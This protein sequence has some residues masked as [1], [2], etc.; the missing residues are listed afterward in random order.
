MK[1]AILPALLI[2]LLTA[3]SVYANENYDLQCTLTDGNQMTLSHS[4]DTVYIAFLGPN[5]D[6]E[7]SDSVMKLD[8]NIDAVRQIKTVSPSPMLTVEATPV[9]FDEKGTSVHVIFQELERKKYVSY[10]VTNSMGREIS[11]MDCKSGTIKTT[12]NLINQGIAGVP[13]TQ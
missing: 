2:S 3:T 5:E 9:D 4:K 1:S 12:P 7:E 13:L 6:P 8:L 10:I 11:S